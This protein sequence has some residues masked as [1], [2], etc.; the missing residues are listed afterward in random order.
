MN[1]TKVKVETKNISINNAGILISLVQITNYKTNDVKL[2]QNWIK[3]EYNIF[4]DSII[5]K[6]YIKIISDENFEDENR[7]HKYKLTKI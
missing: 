2:I 7:K 4:V 3:E 6:E 5:I 1:I